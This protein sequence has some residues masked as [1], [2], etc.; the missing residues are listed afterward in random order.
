MAYSSLALPLAAL[1]MP[2][3]IFLPTYYA[4][5]LGLGFSLVGL[6]LLAARLL[7]VISDPVIGILGDK[8]RS[9]IGRRK[10]WILGGALPTIAGTWLLMI[11]VIPVQDLTGALYLFG[12]SALLYIGWTCMILSFQAWGAELSENYDERSRI[13]AWREGLTVGGILGTLALL[14][15]LGL[16]SK[17]DAADALN[18]ITWLVVVL[19]PVTVFLALRYVPEPQEKQGRKITFAAGLKI[20]WANRP[21]RILAASY[22]VNSMANG[23]PA[24][25]FI[26]YVHHVLNMPQ[27]TNALLFLYF[28]CGFLA[29]PLWLKLSYRFGKHQVWSIAMLW[30]CLFFAFV[31]FIGTQD[32]GFYTAIVVLT[33]LTL[34][35]DLVLP[36]SMQADVVDLDRLETGQRRTGLYF[37]LW[38]MLTKL[39]LALAAGMAFPAL[40]IAGFVPEENKNLWAL[41][42]LYALIP[43]VLKLTAIK[44]MSHYPLGREDLSDIQD[45]LQSQI[46]HHKKNHPNTF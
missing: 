7:D 25:L 40:D 38:G 45:R 1:T 28:L 41:I 24:T 21:F 4:Q 30:A 9:E 17:Q 22:L 11:P 14:A 46:A 34:G 31:P 33:G 44:I 26:L 27:Y 2:V 3:Y 8:T 5:D 39:S 19:I 6:T 32:I 20:L 18:V 15:F 29:V 16:S 36:A 12:S 13:S 43:I 23:L 42:G 35:A 37:A 10:I